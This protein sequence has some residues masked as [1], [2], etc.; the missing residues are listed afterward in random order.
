MTCG[1]SVLSITWSS[2]RET[3]SPW[4][5]PGSHAEGSYTHLIH[6]SIQTN[7]QTKKTWHR[8]K[9]VFQDR[10]WQTSGFFSAF[11]WKSFLCTQSNSQMTSGLSARKSVTGT[12]RTCLSEHAYQWL[13][14]HL[15]PSQSRQAGGGGPFVIHVWCT[16]GEMGDV[17]VTLKLCLCAH[18]LLQ[19][20]F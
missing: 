1:H 11:N 14:L 17:W 10:L 8:S 12:H 13:T 2:A 5:R 9:G 18:P 15:P 19:F 16:R 6:S 3:T 4:Y 20:L 7:K